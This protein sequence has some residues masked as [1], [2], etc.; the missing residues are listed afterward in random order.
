MAQATAARNQTF[1]NGTSISW[2][3]K[4]TGP[5]NR[6]WRA[7]AIPSGEL[8]AAHKDHSYT[9]DQARSP[10]SHAMRGFK[11]AIQ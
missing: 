3:V 11:I 7:A 9:P 1:H 2:D 10:A 5:G 6:Q 4:D 8:K